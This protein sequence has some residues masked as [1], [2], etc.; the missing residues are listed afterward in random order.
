LSLLTEVGVAIALKKGSKMFEIWSYNHD[1]YERHSSAND[2]AEAIELCILIL[3]KMVVNNY[4]IHMRIKYQGHN[5]IEV[6]R[7][8]S[9]ALLKE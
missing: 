5:L 7:E 8:G 6:Y 4:N 2:L 1:G 3:S 9:K